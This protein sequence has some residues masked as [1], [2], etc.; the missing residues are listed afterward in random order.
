M[1]KKDFNSIHSPLYKLLNLLMLRIDDSLIENE[2]L[3]ILKK[4]ILYSKLG[5]KS[6]NVEL[7]K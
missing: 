2:E 3:G 4:N 6:I 7:E 5:V 1:L